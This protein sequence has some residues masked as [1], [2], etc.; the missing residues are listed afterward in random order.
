MN[1]YTSRALI[2]IFTTYTTKNLA[3][4]LQTA[5]DKFLAATY[6]CKHQ[7]KTD[8]TYSWWSGH[9]WSTW[10][11]YTGKLTTEWSEIWEPKAKS[12][13]SH[14]II[15]LSFRF[16]LGMLRILQCDHMIWH[17]TMGSKFAGCRSYGIWNADVPWA[18]TPE[19][20]EVVTKGQRDSKY[21][22]SQWPRC[23]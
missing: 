16:I 4:R 11:S 2:L 14:M 9:G 1:I 3:P 15:D 17:M 19:R 6:A 8:Q 22:R 23:A 12:S 13:T 21:C 7:F 18:V 5:G 10:R 20:S